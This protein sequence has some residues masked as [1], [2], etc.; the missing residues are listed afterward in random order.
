MKWKMV[1]L[2]ATQSYTSV[3]ID[4]NLS[5]FRIVYVIPPKNVMLLPKK[6]LYLLRSLNFLCIYLKSLETR[7][8]IRLRQCILQISQLISSFNYIYTFKVGWRTFPLP[9]PARGWVS[10]IPWSFQTEML[11]FE[12]NLIWSPCSNNFLVEKILI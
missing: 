3:H 8:S 9:L 1:E 12:S 4:H 2:K 5:L 10:N 6:K 11:P 7:P